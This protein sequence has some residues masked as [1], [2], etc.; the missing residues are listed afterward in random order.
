MFYFVQQI[1][2]FTDTSRCFFFAKYVIYYIKAAV[3]FVCLYVC[4]Y[5][6]PPLY[7]RHDRRTATKFGTHTR[8]DMGL[9]LS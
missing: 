3:V 1:D 5:P 6:P 2:R 8:V 9:I 7:F 4:L